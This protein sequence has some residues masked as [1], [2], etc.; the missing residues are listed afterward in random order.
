[1]QCPWECNTD[2]ILLCRTHS[3]ILICRRRLKNKLCPWEWNPQSL[4]CY[5]KRPLWYSS[6]AGSLCVRGALGSV[7]PILFCFVECP[8]WYSSAAGSLWACSAPGSSQS[9]SWHAKRLD[10]QS[11]KRCNCWKRLVRVCACAFVSCMALMLE[12]VGVGVYV[13]VYVRVC[14]LCIYVHMCV[15][16]CVRLFEWMCWCACM[17]F[18]THLCIIFVCFLCSSGKPSSC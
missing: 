12:S 17:R 15:S 14:H 8:L 4:L 16:V 1:M 13:Q 10:A 5:V 7:T 3:L 9:P 6:A 11:W 2:P 18:H